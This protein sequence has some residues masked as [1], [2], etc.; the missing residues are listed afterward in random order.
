MRLDTVLAYKLQL[1]EKGY[2][3]K[4]IFTTPVI[5]LIFYFQ[6]YCTLLFICLQ[7]LFPIRRDSL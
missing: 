2:I 7:M 3:N 6:K 4:D 5:K 1:K